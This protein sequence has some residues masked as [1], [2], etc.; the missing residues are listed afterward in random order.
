[1]ASTSSCLAQPSFLWSDCNTINR[2]SNSSMITTGTRT[3][4][5]SIETPHGK[6]SSAILGPSPTLHPLAMLKSLCSTFKNA[7]SRILYPLV[8]TEEMEELRREILLLEGLKAKLANEYGMTGDID[9]VKVFNE[10]KARAFSDKDENTISVLKDLHMLYQL[11]VHLSSFQ[12]PRYFNFEEDTLLQDIAPMRMIA[13][14][15]S[16]PWTIQNDMA[17]CSHT[18]TNT[19]T[20]EQG[21][22]TLH[23]L[24]NGSP[25]QMFDVTDE[26]SRQFPGYQ[27]MPVV[28]RKHKNAQI[29][30]QDQ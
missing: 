2:M 11:C 27:S 13:L 15:L 24:T 17:Y 9:S 21:V 25:K 30:Y 4:V 23:P 22:H 1:M 10:T 8:S 29:W 18:G 12:L 20:P 14:K 7:L 6:T 16:V 28:A 3:T 19:G 5:P 26:N